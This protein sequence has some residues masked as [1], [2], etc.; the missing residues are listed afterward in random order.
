MGA[1]VAF[2]PFGSVPHVSFLILCLSLRVF[3]LMLTKHKVL[4]ARF[5]DTH[6]ESFCSKYNVLLQSRNYVTKRQSLKLLGE[7]LLNRSNFSIMM[8][9]INSPENLKIMM[10]LLRGQ[11]KDTQ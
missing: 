3:Q 11:T 10:N 8:K 5:L 7:L 2:V 9:Y 4:S 6:F 1:A